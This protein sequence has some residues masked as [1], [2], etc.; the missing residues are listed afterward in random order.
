[1][2]ILL[3]VMKM[4]CTVLGHL[5]TSRETPHVGIVQRR[6]D[7]VQHAEGRG[8]EAEDGEHQATAV[9]AFS[10][11]DSRWMVLLRLPGGRAMIGDA[12]VQQVFAGQFQVGMAAAE[13]A[14]EQ[15]LQTGI[16]LV[17]GFLE[18]RARLAVDL[19]DGVFQGLQRLDQIGVL[20]IQILLALDCCSVNSSMAA[21][22][23]GPRRWIQLL[24]SLM[25]ALGTAFPVAPAPGGWSRAEPCSEPKRTA[26]WWA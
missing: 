3:W 19:A 1:M 8:I 25:Q 23:I 17:E 7:F 12:G 22:L 10:P 16:D 11:P 13:Q 26:S 18:T 14:R 9:S 24:T 20:R 15:L 5:R 4:N 6:V 2:V 21:R